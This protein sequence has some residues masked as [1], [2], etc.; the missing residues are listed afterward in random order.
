MKIIRAFSDTYK[1]PVIGP[2]HDFVSDAH[3]DIEVKIFVS[4][5]GTKLVALAK[6]WKTKPGFKNM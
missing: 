2:L 1:E 3:E 5:K 6:H 4:T